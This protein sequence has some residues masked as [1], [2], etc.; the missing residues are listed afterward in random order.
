MIMAGNKQFIKVEVGKGYGQG[1]LSEKMI[2]SLHLKT[3]DRE[4][5]GHANILMNVI[6]GKEVSEM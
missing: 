5:Q 4:K 3:V 1:G 2:S 6:L